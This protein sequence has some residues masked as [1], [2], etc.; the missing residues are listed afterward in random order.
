MRGV[1]SE[2]H[3]NQA[4]EIKEKTP[5][6]VIFRQSAFLDRILQPFPLATQG[7]EGRA[8]FALPPDLPMGRALSA[9]AQLKTGNFVVSTL[10]KNWL[11]RLR[12]VRQ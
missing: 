7:L 1:S 5:R 2:N 8:L 3:E 12:G 9:R 10:N 11:A 6:L 4:I